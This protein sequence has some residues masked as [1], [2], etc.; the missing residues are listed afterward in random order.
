[1]RHVIATVGRTTERVWEDPVSCRPLLVQPKCCQ[2]LHSISNSPHNH[3][4][5]QS[6]SQTFWSAAPVHV[7]GTYRGMGSLLIVSPIS[8]CRLQSWA[9]PGRG[10]DVVIFAVERN[11]YLTDACRVHS[12]NARNITPFRSHAHRSRWTLCIKEYESRSCLDSSLV[13]VARTLHPRLHQ[14]PPSFWQ[15]GSPPRPKSPGRSCAIGRWAL[16]YG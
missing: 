1:M 6:L 13:S 8:M 5:N 3:D 14:V 7:D 12:K 4:R 2:L 9:N 15:L 11:V 10:E 16:R